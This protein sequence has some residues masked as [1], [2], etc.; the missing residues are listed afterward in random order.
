M[1]KIFFPRAGFSAIK[2]RIASINGKLGIHSRDA[3]FTSIK[4][5]LILS[6]EI[7]PSFISKNDRFTGRYVLHKPSGKF[8]V[9]SDLWNHKEISAKAFGVIYTDLKNTTDIVAG[10]MNMN[11]S[12]LGKKLEFR[13]DVVSGVNLNLKKVVILFKEILK[14]GGYGLKSETAYTPGNGAKMIRLRAYKEQEEKKLT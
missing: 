4:Y 14:Q 10:A 2:G 9:A 13:I 3:A 7:L 12:E 1:G 6:A 5:P 8:A 11:V